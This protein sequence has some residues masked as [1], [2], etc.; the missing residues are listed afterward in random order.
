MLLTRPYEDILTV[1]K[2]RCWGLYS[3]TTNDPVPLKQLDISIQIIHN[4]S[5]VLYSQTY[6]NT[7]SHQL[8]ETEFYFPISPD[9]CFDSFEAEFNDTKIKGVIKKKEKAKKEYDTAIKAGKTA[10]YSEIQEDT[11]DIMKVLIGNIPPN[12]TIKITYSYLQKLD[13]ALKKFWC[14]RLFSSITPRY[15]N[16]VKALLDNDLQLLSSYPT[17]S[18]NNSRAYPWNI[19]VDIQSPSPISFVKSPSHDVITVYGNEN[20]T[21]HITFNPMEIAL[22]NKDFVLLYQNGDESKTDYLLTPFED[23]YCAMVTLFGDFDKKSGAEIFENFEKAKEINSV[24]NYQA[25]KG[26]Y[27]FVLDRSG[28]M[29]GK[30]IEMSRLALILA[31]KSLPEDSFFNVVSFGTNHEFLYPES[32]LYSEVTL[33]ESVEEMEDVKAN[34]GGTDIY[35]PLEKIFSLPVKKGYPRFIFLLT[36]GDVT[37]TQDVLS[38]IKENKM[39]AQVFTLGI[40]NGCSPELIKKAAYHGR[41]QYEFIENADGIHEKVINLLNASLSPCFTDLKLHGDNFDAFV[42]S[43]SPNPANVP[44]LLGGQAVS[45][46]IWLRGD[47]FKQGDG[48]WNLGLELQDSNEKSAKTLKMVLDVNKAIDNQWIPKLGVFEMIKELEEQK[49]SGSAAKENKDILWMMEKDI[50]ESLLELSLKY[51]ILCKETA[52]ICEVSDST[53]ETKNLD[54]IKVIVPS[55]ESSDYANVSQRADVFGGSMFYNTNNMDAAMPRSRGIQPSAR[56]RGRGR[57]RGGGY[58]GGMINERQSVT[59]DLYLGGMDQM[60]MLQS[61]MGNMGMIQNHLDSGPH[62]APQSSNYN[63]FGA[64]NSLP[65]TASLSRAGN[66]SRSRSPPKMKKKS[67]GDRLANISYEKSVLERKTER[68]KKEKSHKFDVEEELCIDESNEE[69]NFSSTIH[70]DLDLDFTRKRR[71][72]KAA[73]ECEP[74]VEKKMKNEG[75]S[76]SG[77]CVDVIMKQAFE[78]Y[79]NWNDNGLMKQVLNGKS[80]PSIPEKLKIDDKRIWMTILVLCWLEIMCK[81]DQKVWQLIHRKGKEWIR[82]QG[83][84][85]DEIANEFGQNK[86]R[87]LFG[88]V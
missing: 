9:A 7:S 52:F 68:K 42:T 69:E 31:L 17:I 14:F 82:K 77:S 66:K 50:K 23:G 51:G 6:E 80:L 43:V 55:I 30:R 4:T 61:K 83:L 78:G 59:R 72:G 18:K 34:M 16:D 25:V 56:G 81:N 67:S 10:A 26:E 79:W 24:E 37:N 40:G 27:I 57:G 8:L 49:K 62:M 73:R 48:K 53:D 20:H 86:I 1:P 39:K 58:G 38:L 65:I 35:N 84:D 71:G 87:E 32:V 70:A 88:L 46:F 21:C 33:K 60:N 63:Y 36:D 76:G 5:K 47:A 45:F 15:N 41:G 19:E 75:G 3:L 11:G 85:Y 12:S 28:S 29:S 64:A 2:K 54:K 74:E 13:I 44:F 22:P